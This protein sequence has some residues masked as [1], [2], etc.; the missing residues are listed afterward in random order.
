MQSKGYL[1][2]VVMAEIEIKDDTPVDE[3]YIY[4]EW[5]FNY[6]TCVA[7]TAFDH[8]LSTTYPFDMPIDTCENVTTVLE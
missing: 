7:K 8:K 1:N 4:E 2:I 3:D 6:Y 5:P